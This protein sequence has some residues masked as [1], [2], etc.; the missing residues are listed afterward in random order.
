MSATATKATG[1]SAILSGVFT[2]LAEDWFKIGGLAI[3][4]ST[5]LAFVHFKRIE[6]NETKRH[7]KAMEKAKEQS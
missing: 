2:A 3:S 4:I 1:L 7:N 6:F 5:F